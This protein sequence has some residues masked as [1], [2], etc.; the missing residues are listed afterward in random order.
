[1]SGLAGGGIE[2]SRQGSGSWHALPTGQEGSRLVTRIDDS[3]LAPGAYALRATAHDRAGNL[4][5]TDRRLDGQPMIVTLPLRAE[6]V[7]AAGKADHR[8]VRR[9]VGRRGH[10]RKVWRR[11]P[12]LKPRVRAA[13]GQRVRIAGRLTNRDGQPISDAPIHVYSQTSPGDEQLAGTLSTDARGR[14][15]YTARATSTR[16]LRFAHPGSPTILPAHDTVEI[17]T[18]GSSTLQVSKRRA[19]NGRS[20][21]FSGRVRGRPLPDVGK[22]V[23]IQVRLSTGWQTFRTL[24]TDP[25]GGWRQ[26]YRF[27]NTCGLDRFRFRARVPKEAGH[28]FETAASRT[29]TVRVRGRPCPS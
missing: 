7:L 6:T 18:R 2:I 4:G 15:A 3:Q 14:F 11:V 9:T 13:F 12:I 21:V 5:S 16:T 20:V 26:R 25:V 8:R 22:L 27:R 1:V 19:L 23:E 24:R 29:V 10:R 28:P 17:L